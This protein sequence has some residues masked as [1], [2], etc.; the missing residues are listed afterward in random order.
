MSWGRAESN[1][2]GRAQ[3]RMYKDVHC[4]EN[5]EISVHKYGISKTEYPLKRTQYIFT[6]RKN[7]QETLSGKK[8]KK[9]HGAEESP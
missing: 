7:V 2:R 5:S 8:K 4:S 6:Q 1:S 3:R 9:K